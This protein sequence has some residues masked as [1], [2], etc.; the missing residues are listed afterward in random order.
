MISKQDTTPTNRRPYRRKQLSG[1]WLDNPYYFYYMLREGT[2]LVVAGYAIMLA[3][4]V[5]RLSQGPLAWHD[6]VASVTSPLTMPLHLLMLAALFYHA[7]TWF[8]LAPRI[9]VIRLGG[10][11]L[12]PAWV[13]VMHWGGCVAITAVLFGLWGGGL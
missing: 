2:A 8:R 3:V 1:W 11:P 9:V 5:L 10:K 4:G 12:P 13:E 6:W 7:L